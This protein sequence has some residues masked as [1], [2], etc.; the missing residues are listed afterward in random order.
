MRVRKISAPILC[1]LTFLLGAGLTLAE[2]HYT[3]APAPNKAIYF[4]H[5]SYTEIANDEFDP[6]V[7]G[8]YNLPPK[9]AILNFPLGPGDSVRTSPE[10]RCEIQF[11]TGTI[12]RLDY[13]TEVQI[14]TILAPSLTSG[15]QISNLVLK[16]G[17]A[18]IMY[19]RYNRPEVFQVLTSNAA[20]KLDNNSV[21][22]IK[23]EEGLSQVW[24]DEGKVRILYGPDK[25]HV[26][27]HKLK[28]GRTASVT[29][30]HQLLKL[31]G[32]LDQE[33]H[34]WNRSMN[35]DFLEM[36]KGKTPLPKPIQKLPKA[37]F[38]FAQKYSYLHGEWLWDSFYGYVW[39]PF[40][41]DYYPWGNWS[42][43]YY[44]Q[45][46]MTN[47]QL[48]WIPMESWGWVP[49]HLGLWIWNKNK[50][51][52]WLPGS[53]FAPAWAAWRFFFGS[54]MLAWRPLG[55]WDWAMG[56]TYFYGLY[57]DLAYP[58][59]PGIDPNKGNEKPA[60]QGGKVGITP[61]IYPPYQIPREFKDT[62]KKIKQGIA[63]NDPKLMADIQGHVREYKMVGARDLN[64][65][66]IHE[67]MIDSRTTEATI[68]SKVYRESPNPSQAAVNLYW[69]Q[70]IRT[71]VQETKDPSVRERGRFIQE[72]SSPSSFRDH[73]GST[74]QP[75]E[76][77]GEH[78]FRDWNPDAKH[79]SRQDV[80][81]RYVSRHNAIS[82]PEISFSRSGQRRDGAFRGISSNNS[83]RGDSS[84]SGS[85]S[86]GESSGSAGSTRA[87]GTSSSSSGTSR[88]SGGTRK[89]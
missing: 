12:L 54:N 70:G 52:L 62:L 59:Y 8:A 30:D 47:D 77:R 19:K 4:A 55:P 32:G 42:P 64:M 69:I 49:Y 35:A 83:Y 21:S 86:S 75:V 50:G 80:V 58:V 36:H 26:D 29:P 85:A 61:K 88:G 5:I 57:S 10:R 53:A 87:S 20:V 63:R 56:S 41:N 16:Q 78:A 25:K 71:Q 17:Q 66:R 18:Y 76:L 28:K 84:G 43:Y 27:T 2:T 15:S 81:L 14:E 67:R 13:D 3:Y 72:G 6:L 24:V 45:W 48:F 65:P 22:A 37:V 1:L 39:R 11:D 33:F 31:T 82:A 44:G 46:H 74:A 23:L 73:A 9:K 34:N 38:Y 60:E 89:K 68:T 51:W 7:F 40:Y 79:A